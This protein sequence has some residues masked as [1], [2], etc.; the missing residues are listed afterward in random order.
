[1][2]PRSL[3]KTPLG[4]VSTKANHS[5]DR[6]HFRSPQHNS[7][8]G[9]THHTGFFRLALEP[10]ILSD[11]N[12]GSGSMYNRPFCKQNQ[13]P[14]SQVLQLQIRPR[15]GGNRCPNTTMGRGDRVCL[16]PVQLSSQMP[17]ESNPEAAT[18][19]LIC[20]VWA[21]QSCYAHSSNW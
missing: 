12:A 17:T 16:S 6:T 4:L 13:S 20:P 2:S 15:G 1:M 11:T 19:T 3:C 18:V 10:A 7:R 5:E 21:T 14:A 8:Q 9:V